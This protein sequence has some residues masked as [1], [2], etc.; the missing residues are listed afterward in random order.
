MKPE[1][2]YERIERICELDEIIL[3][4]HKK[5]K[6][7]IGDKDV[8]QYNHL[9]NS[10]IQSIQPLHPEYLIE[11]LKKYHLFLEDKEEEELYQQKE[12]L[13][14]KLGDFIDNINL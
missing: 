8:I 11:N 2:L 13:K 9:V 3:E 6:L 12:N 7:E 5:E 4:R 14:N 10:I 1:D